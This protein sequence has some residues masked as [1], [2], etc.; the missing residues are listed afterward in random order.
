[1]GTGTVAGHASER[2][3]GCGSWGSVAGRIPEVVSM[4]NETPGDGGSFGPGFFVRN[5]MRNAHVVTTRNVC[6]DGMMP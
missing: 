3:S 4:A 5:P 6:P 2:G 1:M